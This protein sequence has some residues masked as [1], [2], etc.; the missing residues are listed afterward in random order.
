[1]WRVSGDVFDSWVDIWVSQGGS[2]GWYGIGIDNSLDIAADLA[3]YGGPDA[4]NDLDMLIVGLNGKGQIHGRGMSFV[5][6]QTHMSLWCMA[7]SPLMI[8]CD[9]TRMDQDTARL[10]TNRE[11]LAINQDALGVPAR[12]AKRFGNC[13]VW[14]KP[15][16]GGAR[17]VALIN[18][19]ASGQDV[20]LRAGDIGLLD[21]PKL[22]RDL[23]E[24]KDVADFGPSLIR[25]VQPHQ[26]LLFQVSVT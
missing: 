19:G 25:R 13:E 1:M 14:V 22:V 23:W 18:R 26:T 9:V 8:G 10:L 7:C 5:E 17:A 20:T 2:A 12:R 21:S 4:W 24:Q 3:T 15:L 16:A 11:V 6:Y